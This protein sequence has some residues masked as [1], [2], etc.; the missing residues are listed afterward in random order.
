MAFCFH[1][2]YIPGTV[3]PLQLLLHSLLQW[4]D[5]TFCLVANGCAATEQRAL[6][7][8]CAGNSRLAY[9]VLATAQVMLHG[10]ALDILQGQN[11]TDYFCFM[12][13]DIYAIAE[14][15]PTFLPLVT[16]Y[17]GLF[18]G[19]P[20]RHP[21][22][23]LVLPEATAFMAGPYTHTPA[24]LCL[25]T[26]FFAI[27]NN[28]TI[29]EVRRETGIGFRK[30]RW[31]EIPAPYQMQLQAMGLQYQIYDTAKLLNLVLHWHGHA[32][33]YQPCPALRHIEAVSRFAVIQQHAW[34]R[35][36]RALGGRW[37]RKLTGQK[38]EPS[39][40]AA[41]PYLSQVLLA[42]ANGQPLPPQPTLAG[43]ESD[44]WVAQTKEELLALHAEFSKQPLS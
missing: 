18:S 22:T 44:A 34:W 20:L 15:L 6:Q 42:L 7:Q 4:S 16:R 3:K 10:E 5:C 43:A 14:F 29:T 36:L 38:V 27:Y 31:A 12:D 25:G 39:Y 33:H 32:L 11:Q 28:R 13:S 30:Y 2:I 1:I 21:P 26:T 35:Q 23:G 9:K 37:R 41:L 17:T 24:Q 19:M 8:L 40:A